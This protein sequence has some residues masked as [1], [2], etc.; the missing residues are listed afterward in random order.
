VT[1]PV[2]WSVGGGAIAREGPVEAMASAD[3]NATWEVEIGFGKG[4]YLRRRAAEAPEARFLGIERVGEYFRRLAR[5]A[6]RDRLANLVLVRGEALYLLSAVLPRGFA[7]AVHLYF[8]DP[9]PKTRHERRRLLDVDTVDLVAGLLEPGGT[10]FFATDSTAYG[11]AVRSTLESLP[12]VGVVVRR[13]VWD[14]GPRTNYEAKY[15]REGRPIVR[16]EAVR[17]GAVSAPHPGGLRALAAAV[18][19]KG[20]QRCEG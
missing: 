3:P 12:D 13:Q 19:G 15:V 16:L 9:W 10:L 4:R 6:A 7:R 14:D 18:T 20:W 2:G 17:R 1:V 8:P 5:I 11:S